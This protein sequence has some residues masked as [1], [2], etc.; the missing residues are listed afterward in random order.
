M[1]SVPCLERVE[2]P[3]REHHR[4]EELT[5]RPEANGAMWPTVGLRIPYF[6]PVK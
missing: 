5:G 6:P 2:L 4:Q 3:L 1:N